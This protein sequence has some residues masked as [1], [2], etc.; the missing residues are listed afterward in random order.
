VLFR[1][2]RRLA[3]FWFELVELE[4]AGVVCVE[5]AGDGVCVSDISAIKSSEDMSRV[6]IVRAGHK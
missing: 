3:E 1:G 6:S 4:V 5:A 2:G